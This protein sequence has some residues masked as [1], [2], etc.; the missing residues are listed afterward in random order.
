[1]TACTRKV[2]PVQR[3]RA[4]RAT[5]HAAGGMAAKMNA[6]F[7]MAQKE[8]NEKRISWLGKKRTAK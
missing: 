1:M 7:R 2:R 8:A 5:L 4:K 3:D 6:E